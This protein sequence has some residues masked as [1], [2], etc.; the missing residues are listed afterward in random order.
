[1]GTY[2]ATT[3][4]PSYTIEDCVDEEKETN[5]EF[6]KAFLYENG[7]LRKVYTLESENESQS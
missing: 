7:T 5:E 3:Y 6:I 4:S 2:Y 1:M